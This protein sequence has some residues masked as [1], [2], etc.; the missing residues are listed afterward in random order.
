[1]APTTVGTRGVATGGL[2]AGEV[3]LAVLAL[4]SSVLTVGF[5][6][7]A[8]VGGGMS[9]GR[10]GLFVGLSAF[11]AV[12]AVRSVWELGRRLRSLIRTRSERSASSSST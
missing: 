9:P 3:L 2:G 4:W 6:Y 7:A 1:M 11:T 10:R 12:L 5:G 8:W